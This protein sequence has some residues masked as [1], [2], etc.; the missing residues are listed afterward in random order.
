MDEV[1]RG[2]LPGRSARE[3]IPFGGETGERK[4]E[5]ELLGGN[6]LAARGVHKLCSVTVPKRGMREVEVRGRSTEGGGW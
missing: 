6:A 3:T 4:K 2:D 1:A 5:E